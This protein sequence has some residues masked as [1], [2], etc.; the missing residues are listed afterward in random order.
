MANFINYKYGKYA[1]CAEYNI[2]VPLNR[3]I[4]FAEDRFLMGKIWKYRYIN[5]WQ[6]EY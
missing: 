6:C 3:N 5:I 4:N 1:Q 2:K